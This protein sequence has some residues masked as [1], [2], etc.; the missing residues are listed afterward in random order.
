MCVTPRKAATVALLKDNH[1]SMEVL[2]MRRHLDDRFLP[3]Y[4]VFPGGALDRQ[5]YDISFQM[6]TEL[7]ILKD[8]EGDSAK[9]YGFILCGIR[10]TFEESGLLL[11]IDK[12]GNYPCINTMESVAKFSEYRNLVFEQKISF[13]D[14]LEK[15]CL[16]PAVENFHYIKRWITPPLFPIRYDTRFFT[17]AAPIDQ[18]IS[19]DGNELVDFNWMTPGDALQK[20]RK[21]KIKLVMPTIKTLEY[22][23]RFRSST[24]VIADLQK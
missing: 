18:E 19:H 16:I 8:F 12:N 9:Y 20:Y 10:E 7:R 15:E 23:T 2:L 3:D 11:A 21:N 4:C 13:S 14:M 17:A 1:D 5:D 22:L 24:D 6:N